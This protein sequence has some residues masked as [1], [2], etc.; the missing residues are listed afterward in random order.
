MEART[1]VSWKGLLA[2]AVAILVLLV[3]KYGDGGDSDSLL[4]FSLIGQYDLTYEI[5]VQNYEVLGLTPSSD[6]TLSEIKKTYK[7]LAAKLCVF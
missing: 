3:L 2:V 5:F 6:L 4:I 1:G 7:K